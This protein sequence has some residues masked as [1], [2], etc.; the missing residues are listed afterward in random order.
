MKDA[1]ATA[2]YGS[3]GSNGVIIITTKK[4][5]KGG[6]KVSYNGSMTISMKKKTVDVLNG[7]EFRALI[8]EKWG[9]NSDAYN[10]LGTANTDWQDLIYRTAISQDHGVTI[11]GSAGAYL[12]YRVSL[13]YTDQQGILKTSDFKRYTASFNLNPSLLDNHLNINLNAKGMY[14]HSKY[15]DT[16]AISAAVN[17]DPTQDPYSYTSNYHKTTYGDNLTGLLN[18]FNGF[19]HGQ[20]R[21]TMV[22]RHGL[23]LIMN[24]QPR[25]HYLYSVRKTTVL[26]AVSLSVVPTSITKY[27]ALRI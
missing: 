13:G 5:H 18:N 16:D 24:W 7:D 27:M 15:A 10:A 1:S 26:T 11:S 23:I 22:I 4:G 9:E 20:N 6:V 2:I 25:T 21:V 8:K 17:M 12:P 19:L 14:A 3:R